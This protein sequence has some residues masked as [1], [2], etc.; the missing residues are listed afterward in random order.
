MIIHG[1]ITNRDYLN[2]LHF[3]RLPHTW[4][5]T[6]LA[7]VGGVCAML[8]A[9]ALGWSVEGFDGV[10]AAYFTALPLLVYGMVYLRLRMWLYLRLMARDGEMNNA[11]PCTYT[12][13]DA[14]MEFT[15]TMYRC[16]IPFTA[17][18]AVASHRGTHYLV[19]G[20]HAGFIIPAQ[21]DDGDGAAFITALRACIQ[22]PRT[23]PC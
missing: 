19:L 21:I 11:G 14:T 18:R 1:T 13:S 10:R 12:L 22:P 15:G 20:N 16:S 4:P 9:M 5:L 8:A 3:T 23:P 7:C 6:V 2:C 17:I